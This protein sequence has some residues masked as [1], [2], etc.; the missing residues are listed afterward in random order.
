MRFGLDC[1]RDKR[2]HV[3]KN[4]TARTNMSMWCS[5]HVCMD[6]VR[7]VTLVA[8]EDGNDLDIRKGIDRQINWCKVN[9]KN[10]M[11]NYF[12]IY[13]IYTKHV[14]IFTRDGFFFFFWLLVSSYRIPSLVSSGSY[15]YYYHS[16]K[17]IL[18]KTWKWK[19]VLPFECR[20]IVPH[21][22]RSRTP[23]AM[24]D[25][26]SLGLTRM[27]SVRMRILCFY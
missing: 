9:H 11:Y 12:L 4:S 3:E 5:C 15:Y 24:S 19:L 20:Q 10:K 22:K 1:I 25:D 6:N 18:M 14:T 13:S 26:M 17:R 2:Y 27:A 8:I 21:N 16:I 7:V 23:W